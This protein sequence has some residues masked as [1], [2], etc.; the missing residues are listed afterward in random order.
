MAFDGHSDTNMDGLVVPL[1]HRPQGVA[2]LVN[3]HAGTGRLA[4]QLVVADGR[5]IVDFGQPI[6]WVGLTP[7]EA[8]KL[9]ADLEVAVRY[10]R[11]LHTEAPDGT[12]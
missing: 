4:I 5:V 2:T 1:G 9:S 7:D 3:P 8:G 6:Q 12:V 10:A 11:T